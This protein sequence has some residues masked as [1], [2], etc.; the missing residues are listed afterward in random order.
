MQLDVE[1]VAL[2]AQVA[3]RALHERGQV[4]D[5]G[6]RVHFLLGHEFVELE[7]GVRVG[8]LAVLEHGHELVLGD[9]R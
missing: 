7:L 3:Q 4:H 8:E 2:E 9:L 5:L 6:R 1:R